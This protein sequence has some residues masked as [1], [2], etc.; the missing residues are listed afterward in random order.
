MNHI[1]NVKLSKKKMLD[2]IQAK[3]V[4]LHQNLTQQDI[5]DKSIEFIDR[6]F[7]HFVQEEIIIPKLTQEK[8]DRIKKSVYTGDI[9]YPALSNDDLLYGED[10]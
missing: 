4:L 8:C 3:L 9:L 5:L 10:H 7:D 1:A 6:H 2:E